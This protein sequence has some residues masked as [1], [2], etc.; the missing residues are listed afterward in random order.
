MRVF[1]KEGATLTEITKEISRYKVDTYVFSMATTD[2]I[3][4]ASDFP[5]NH[6]YV[7]M[8]A[9]VNDNVAELEVAYWSNDSWM[10]VVDIDDHTDAFSRSGFVTFTPDKNEN[11]SM[12]D[13][14]NN[15]DTID[16][17]E[18]IVVYDKYWIK[19]TVSADLDNSLDLQF[20]GNI[21]SDDYDLYAEF[22][23]FNDSNFLTAFEAAKTSWQEQHVKAAE[24]IIQELKR[25]NVILGAEQILVRDILIP[26]SVSKVAEMLFN[27]F[28][29]DYYEQRDSARKEYDKRIDLSNY[30][31]DSNNNAIPEHQEVR[32]KQ[33]WLSR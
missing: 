1:F 9:A 3:Y 19:L 25:K 10:P 30:I 18:D 14:S 21:F 33:G 20:I 11:W 24:I 22:P 17:L 6:F 29:K 5:L 28:G 15:G 4:I 12:D 7:K 27:S 26:A 32:M 13:T 2:A 31:V 8:G 16:D 23:I